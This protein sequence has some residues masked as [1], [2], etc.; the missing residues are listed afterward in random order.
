[1]PVGIIFPPVTAGVTVN[2]LPLHIA[3]GMFAITGLGL[4]VTVTVNVEVQVFGAVPNCAVTV[5]VTV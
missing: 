2:V 4:T 3:S 5:Y 1:V